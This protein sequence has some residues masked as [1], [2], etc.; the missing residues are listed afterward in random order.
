[1]N[2]DRPKAQ[3]LLATGLLV[4]VCVGTASS[5]LA[6]VQSPTNVPAP[7]AYACVSR[8]PNS[9]VWQRTLTQTN[10][11]GSVRTNLQ[12]YTEI[13]TGICYLAGTQYLDSAEVID[14]V[15][16]GAPAAQGRYQV[17]WSANANTA[18]GAIA[19]STAD[20]KTLLSTVCGLTYFDTA[21]GS[22]ILLTRLQDC[23]ATIVGPNV[24]IYSNAFGNVLADIRYSYRKAGMSQD[25]VLRQNLPSPAAYGLNPASTF[26]GVMTEFINPP[27]PVITTVTNNGIADNRKLDFGDMQMGMGQAF[28]APSNSPATGGVP[29]TKCWTNID[30]RT[31]LIEEVP[32]TAVSNLLSS[33]HSSTLAPDKSKVRRTVLLDPPLRPGKA[34][35]SPPAV[36][37]VPVVRV[38]KTTSP[39]TSFVLDYELLGS[40]ADFTFQGGTTYLVSD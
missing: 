21:T 25:V 9:R 5:A 39:E 2:A 7:G 19:L 18:G 37:A 6:Q 23:T 24:L 27:A 30:G 28:L 4:A 20:N 33:L 15:A 35:T 8:G 12:S 16:G 14:A 40:T 26:L 36:P 17:F 38:A 1:M 3:R 10:A 29:V 32:Y 31:F 11:D 34:G 13:A 22:N